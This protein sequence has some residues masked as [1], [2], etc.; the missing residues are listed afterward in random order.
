VLLRP[1]PDFYKGTRPAP[2]DVLLLLEVSDTSLWYDRSVKLRLYARAGIR[3]YWIVD[4]I[5]DVVEV[6]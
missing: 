1:R 2:A 5:G 6:H 3:E 4:V